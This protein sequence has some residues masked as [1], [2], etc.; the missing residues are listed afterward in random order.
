MHPTY[1]SILQPLQRGG[2]RMGKGFWFCPSGPLSCSLFPSHPSP[3]ELQTR[4][5]ASYSKRKKP[6]NISFRLA[7]GIANSRLPNS[8]CLLRHLLYYSFFFVLSAVLPAGRKKR[9]FFSWFPFCGVTGLTLRF[10][11]TRRSRTGYQRIELIDAFRFFPSAEN[12]Y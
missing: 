3:Q 5:P 1:Y 2:V 6:V 9:V 8:L 11:P 10:A 12:Y 7:T 4:L